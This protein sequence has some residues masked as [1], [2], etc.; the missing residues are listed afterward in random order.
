VYPGSRVNIGHSKKK[1]DPGGRLAAP[2]KTKLATAAV[3]AVAILGVAGILALS[4]PSTT[5]ILV[6]RQSSGCI[7][8][9]ENGTNLTN[10]TTT[11][12]NVN[13]G[14]GTVITETYD[15]VNV[16]TTTQTLSA[17]TAV[18]SN[19]AVTVSYG[20]PIALPSTM[21]AGAIDP[22]SVILTMTASAVTSGS[23][24]LVITATC[25]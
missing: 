1:K 3:M 6:F 20:G 21:P 22:F 14:P 25:N 7:I 19:G 9:D 24:T 12:S 18:P 16:G 5:L 13:P 4:T 11:L 15:V 17:F 10:Q 2:R 8:Q 23:T